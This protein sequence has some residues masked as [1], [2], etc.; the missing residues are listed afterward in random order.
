MRYGTVAIVGR[1]N[2]GKS[3]FLNAALGQPL[4]IVSPQPQTTR[5]TLLGVLTSP[6]AQLAFI[7]TPGLHRPKTEL[8]RRMNN[9]AQASLRDADVA[10]FITDIFAMKD[11]LEAKESRNGDDDATLIERI[12]PELPTVLVINKIDKVK[13]KDELLPFMQTLNQRRSFQATVPISALSGDGVPL[14]LAALIELLPEGPAQF[15]ADTLT[16]RPLA[17]FAREYVRE[18]ICQI[19]SQEVPHSCAVT[20]DKVEELTTG[21]HVAATIHVEKE[22]QRA[23]LLGHGGQRIKEI[24]T[25]ARERLG[26]LAE[27]PVHLK[28]FVRVTERWRNVARQ[29][30]ELG[31]VDASQRS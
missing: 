15:A 5:E 1:T 10:L 7:D 24:G 21:L 17:F 29:L 27:Q 11:A 28:L 22:G 18:Q 31:Y 14:V 30:S 6:E 20:L 8:G 2:V 25:R 12:P 9:V 26:V 13:K 3:T 4:A 19:T 16:D 23:I